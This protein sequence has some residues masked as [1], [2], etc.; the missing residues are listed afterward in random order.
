[1]Q[2]QCQVGQNALLRFY[3][4]RDLYLETMLLA[5]F[6][7]P[8]S[9]LYFISAWVD[10][11]KDL[12]PW[13]TENKQKHETAGAKSRSHVKFAV[14]LREVEEKLDFNNS[15][16]P[17]SIKEAAAV[18]PATK[19]GRKRKLDDNSDIL[20]PSANFSQ[21]SSMVDE[22]SF[23]SP[24]LPATQNKAKSQPGA[25][26][27]KKLPFVTKKA[28]KEEFAVPSQLLGDDQVAIQSL[29][30]LPNPSQPQEKEPKSPFSSI[31]PAISQPLSLGM[32]KLDQSVL[33]Q[34]PLK[35]VEKSPVTPISPIIPQSWG[36]IGFPT[37]NAFP[38]TQVYRSPSCLPTQI[39][40][41]QECAPTQLYKSPGVTSASQAVPLQGPVSDSPLMMLN[42]PGAEKLVV[43]RPAKRLVYD[44]V[45]EMLDDNFKDAEEKHSPVK[46]KEV[47]PTAKRKRGRQKASAPEEMSV[48]A[49]RSTLAMLDEKLGVENA[50]QLGRQPSVVQ[51]VDN[52]VP[53]FDEPSSPILLKDTTYGRSHITPRT[54]AYSS[55]LGT[56]KTP[57]RE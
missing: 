38:P 44:D 7:L 5:V 2:K 25:L 13:M 11:Y 41:T 26:E 17:S 3:G 8:I 22:D 34:T 4:T 10:R 27:D 57:P 40:N 32:S 50:V 37:P 16:A 49:K 9:N 45:L 21:A 18:K 19:R 14:A 6:L 24:R 35:Q 20:S 48:E 12:E 53:L 29:V 55:I 39:Y 15:E 23:L 46:V 54:L 51:S 31:D 33:A 52:S 56:T 1:V 36:S 30:P 42:I 43:E 47:N 28:R